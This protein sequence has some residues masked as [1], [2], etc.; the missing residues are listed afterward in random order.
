MIVLIAGVILLFFAVQLVDGFKFFSTW[1]SCRLFPNNAQIQRLA[2]YLLIAVTILCGYLLEDSSLISTFLVAI[3]FAILAS[4]GGIFLSSNAE[5]SVKRANE[6][7][8][9]AD[10][11]HA[12]EIYQ[13][14]IAAPW[15]L[16][17]Y[18]FRKEFEQYWS[19][20]SIR[21]EVI[22][23]WRRGS[24]RCNGCGTLIRGKKIHVDHIKPRSK[25]PDLIYLK[26]NLQVLCNK[27]NMYKHNYDGEDWRDVIADRK[28]AHAKRR[29]N[30]SQRTG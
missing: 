29:R 9:L 14:Y 3:L 23:T 15:L 5:K 21:A 18:D 6:L 30:R 13:R 4:L 20:S 24:K 25:Y 16:N 2:P 17:N 22:S 19:W 7:Q 8:R 1:L 28:M 26:S 12:A 11:K 27:C 10:I